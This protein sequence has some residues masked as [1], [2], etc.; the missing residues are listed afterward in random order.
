M[1]IEGKEKPSSTDAVK[2]SVGSSQFHNVIVLPSID[3]MTQKQSSPIRK[4]MEGRK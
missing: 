4:N 2:E 1:P 3:M